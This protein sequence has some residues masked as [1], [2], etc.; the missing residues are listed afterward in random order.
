MRTIGSGVL[1]LVGLGTL[2]AILGGTQ[3]APALDEMVQP[4]YTAQG[5]LMAGCSWGAGCYE[6][7]A[8]E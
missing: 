2:A 7:T 1:V 6:G 4:A 8:A 5:D 3:A